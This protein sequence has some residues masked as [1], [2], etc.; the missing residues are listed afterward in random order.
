MI[1]NVALGTTAFSRDG[2]KTWSPRGN[3]NI[4]A[5]D[6]RGITSVPEPSTLVLLGSGLLGIAVVRRK[7]LNAT[8]FVIVGDGEASSL[9]HT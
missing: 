2:G 3:G 8:S 4:G 7:L 6:V 9:K 1:S 5:F